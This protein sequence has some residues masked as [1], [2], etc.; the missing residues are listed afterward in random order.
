M[1]AFRRAQSAARSTG[2]NVEVAVLMTRGRALTRRHAKAGRPGAAAS[3]GM[4]ARPD[5]HENPRAAAQRGASK[6][7]KRAKVIVDGHQCKR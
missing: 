3:F 4:A 6:S 1:V 7:P 2:Y 5:W